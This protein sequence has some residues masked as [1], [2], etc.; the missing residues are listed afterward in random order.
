VKLGSAALG[1]YIKKSDPKAS[2][3]EGP[4][5]ML[6][7]GE[8]GSGKTWCARTL[9]KY[10]PIL[11]LNLDQR[12]LSTFKDL[13]EGLVTE[14]R[15][16]NTLDDPYS[17]QAADSLVT[18][19]AAEKGQE[20]GSIFTDTLT[21]LGIAAMNDVLEIAG[22]HGQF[23]FENDYGPQ[24]SRIEHFVFMISA[25]PVKHFRVLTA[26]DNLVKDELT[27][28]FMQT[29]LV[30]GQLKKRMP[31][32]FDEV[33]FAERTGE[34]DKAKY[35]WITRQNRQTV[36]RTQIPGLEERIPQDFNFVMEKFKASS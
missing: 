9:E 21:S 4:L 32:F 35:Q 12:R 8:V 29:L 3:T 24:M 26:H 6:I 13:P 16:G 36:A 5:N 25:F 34:G 20:W 30:T 23:P 10:G 15:F 11:F 17:F 1:Q 28:S 27:G 7:H 22:R 14:Y 19:L 31:G 2:T 33:Y 18:T